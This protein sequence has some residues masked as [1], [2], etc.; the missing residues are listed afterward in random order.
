MYNELKANVFSK[1]PKGIVQMSIL[2]CEIEQSTTSYRSVSPFHPPTPFKSRLF[3]IHKSWT[4]TAKNKGKKK[5]KTQEC[6]QNILM[7]S[8]QF[9]AKQP[10][11]PTVNWWTPFSYLRTTSSDIASLHFEW[12]LL[13]LYFVHL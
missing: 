5:N 11:S 10:S 12:L 1:L 4:E 6:M 13:F 3:S 7:L 8:V 2:V 9:S